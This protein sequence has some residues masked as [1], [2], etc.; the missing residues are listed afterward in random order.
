MEAKPKNWG[1]VKGGLNS[2]GNTKTIKTPHYSKKLAEVVGIILGDGNLHKYVKGKKVR[3]YSIRISGDKNKDLEYLS[4]YVTNLFF[5][6][7]G[8]KGHIYP[9][10]SSNAVTLLFYSKKLVEFFE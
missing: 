8:I 5:M 2:S 10:K 1:Q 6:L 3:C 9:S 4:T 7:F